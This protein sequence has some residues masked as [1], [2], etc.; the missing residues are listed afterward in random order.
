MAV[1][2]SIPTAGWAACSPVTTS[3][4][5]ACSWPVSKA[6]SR[7]AAPSDKGSGLKVDNNWNGTLRARAGI[8]IDR[9]L[10]YG[11]GGL[12]VGNLE[13]KP[14][15]AAATAGPT[16][17]GRSAAASR[18]PSPTTSSAVSSTATPTTAPTSTT[19]APKT[20]GRLQFEPGHGGRRLQVLDRLAPTL[21]YRRPRPGGASSFADGHSIAGR[22]IVRARQA[23][24]STSVQ[25]RKPRRLVRQMR[26]ST[27]PVAIARDGD[28]PLGQAGIG[29]DEA[30]ARPPTGLV[31][32]IVAPAARTCRG[33]RSSR[34][35]GG[36][37]RNSA[38]AAGPSR[39]RASPIG[40]G[41]GPAASGRRR[42]Q[43]CCAAGAGVSTQ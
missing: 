12:A 28:A 1:R 21:G 17:A 32:G 22:V 10:I 34:R 18:R 9:F 8:A 29:D 3:R 2:R 11:T 24:L 41:Q 23:P 26:T 25:R 30:P 27:A 13:V 7:S 16:P 20:E 31:C 6:T 14:P 37:G 5:A 35:R 15:A 36:R 19:P 33:C 38:P 42:R 43:G 40:T 39:C 4:P